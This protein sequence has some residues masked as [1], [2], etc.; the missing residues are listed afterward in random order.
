MKKIAKKI[1][2][3][4]NPTLITNYIRYRDGYWRKMNSIID[5]EVETIERCCA[6]VSKEKV[7]FIDCGCNDGT[8]LK[9]FSKY[10]TESEFFGFEV[11]KEL[12]KVAR[13]KFI[14]DKRIN[15]FEVG[16]ANN[17]RISEL[18]LPKSYGVNFRGGSSILP[19]KIDVK[20]IHQTR[21]VLLIDFAEFLMD[22]RIRRPRDYLVVKMD[23]EGAEFE[24]LADIFKRYESSG[25]KLLDYLII[26][27]HEKTLK[28]GDHV[29]NYEDMLEKMEV[30]VSQ[31][32]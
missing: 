27:W 24:I 32:V 28:G 18:Y 2:E 26:E 20:N 12:V 21:N 25:E 23:I 14:Q 1:V 6:E 31:W 17:Q 22:I 8:V 7:V 4:I 5:D 10:W 16:V 9:R 19:N 11:Q 15:I 30:E 13:K 3:K 29:S